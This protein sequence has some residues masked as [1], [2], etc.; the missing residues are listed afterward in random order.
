MSP[1]SSREVGEPLSPLL[2]AKLSSY[3]PGLNLDAVRLHQG[4]PRYVRGRPAGYVNRNRIYL[5]PGWKSDAD[6]EALALLAHEL[7]HVRQ[8]RELGAWRFRWAYLREY[9]AG[10]LA[11]LGHEEAYRNISFERVARELEERVRHDFTRHGTTA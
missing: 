1:R 8:Y 7:V 4:V 2:R 10:R 6:A 11:Q 5:V 9:L 3:F